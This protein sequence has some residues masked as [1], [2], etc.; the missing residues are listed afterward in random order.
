MGEVR[1][2]VKQIKCERQ[3]CGKR[4]YIFC[5]VVEWMNKRVRISELVGS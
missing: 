4:E 3:S 2:V 5:R 1:R